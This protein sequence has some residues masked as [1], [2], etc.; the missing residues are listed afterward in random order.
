MGH[1][2]L[3]GHHIFS[4]IMSCRHMWWCPIDCGDLVEYLQYMFMQNN[5]WNVCKLNKIKVCYVMVIIKVKYKQYHCINF[6]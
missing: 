3:C 5:N 1:G 6:P 4:L 2:G